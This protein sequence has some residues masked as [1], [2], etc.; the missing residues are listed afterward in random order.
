MT[1]KG[2]KQKSNP[3][4]KY[5]LSEKQEAFV[6]AV[7]TEGLDPEAAFRKVYDCS[8]RSDTRVRSDAKAMLK[9]DAVAARIEQFVFERKNEKFLDE[10]W[11]VDMLKRTAI[12][13]E[14]T[15]VGLKALELLGKHMAMFVDRQTVEDP[16][17]IRATT[18]TLFDL[19]N[20]MEK[21]EDVQDEI[22][23]LADKEKGAG[24]NI[25]EF[26][27]KDGTDG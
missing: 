27:I 18:D 6:N 11:V 5:V 9:N 15:N 19:A 7:V 25:Y 1:K 22:D 26:E 14:G 24:D 10:R 8:S 20:R 3:T 21:G 2:Q 17:N 4:R 12:S 23:K 13:K 16:G